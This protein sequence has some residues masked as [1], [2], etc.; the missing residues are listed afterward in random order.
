MERRRL[1]VAMVAGE[2]SGDHL[3]AGL[4]E[5]LRARRPATTF[6]GVGGP[7][8]A[9][10]GCEIL[11]DMERIG[12]IGLD[13][14]LGKLPGIVAIRRRLLARFTAAPPDLFVGVD[15]PDFN[16]GLEGKL[17]RTGVTCVHYVSPTVWA[18]RGY[19]IRKIR[20]CINHMLTLFPFEADYYRRH[21]VPVTCVGHPM[22]DQI[23]EPNRAAA[24]RRL[25]LG[26]GLLIA[27]LPGSRRSEIARLGGVLIDAARRILEQHPG[28]EFVL[29]FANQ[30]A[31]ECFN[32]IAGR[33]DHG[34][35]GGLPVHTLDAPSDP[36]ARD[37][38]TPARLALEACDVAILASG[39]AALE[40]ALLRRP[41]IVVYKLAAVS[42]WLMRR[43]RHVDHYSMPN[44][45]L[46]APMVPELIQDRATAANIAEQTGR[47]LGDA[48]RTADLER[49]FADLHRALRRGADARAAD[50]VLQLA[51]AR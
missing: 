24:R 9:A 10:A 50:T 30:A 1:R 48:R 34:A 42:Y 6:V 7:K 41:H 4:I 26:D 28:A 14:L 40:A 2:P 21:R 15:A 35:S 8:M 20:R 25:N 31:A 33:H 16:L 19:R 12:V 11:F 46:P 13:G 36:P 5:A 51:G 18:W 39:T 3:A 22:A 27:L 38:R 44:Q 49:H 45:L 32:T 17:K 37:W 23:S 29:P 43:L 47:L